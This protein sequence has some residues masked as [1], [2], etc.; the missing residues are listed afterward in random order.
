MYDGGSGEVGDSAVNLLQPILPEVILAAFALLL[1]VG[2]VF[3]RREIL[4]ALALLGPAVSATALVGQM[5]GRH[6]LMPQEFF[7]GMFVLDDFGFFFRLAILI[8]TF[9]VALLSVGERLLPR[10]FLG[11]YFSLLLFSALGMMF[12]VSTYDMLMLFLAF[13]FVGIGSYVLTGFLK[14]NVK[15]AEAG[16]KYFLVGTFSSAVMLYGL[17]LIFGLSGSTHLGSAAGGNQPLLKMAILLFLVGAG[18]KISMVPFHMWAP[19]AYEGAP[20]PI[21][22]FISVVPKI[23]GLAVLFRIFW[24]GPWGE[25]MTAFPLAA[26]SIITMTVGNLGALAQSNIKRML[27]YSSIAQVGYML[28][29]FV[30]AAP[31]GLLGVALYLLA[32]MVMN[33]GAFAVVIAV[34]NR[35]GGEDLK[36]FAGL[37]QRSPALA[38]VMALF[39]LSLAGIPPTAGFLGKF[40]VFGAAIDK[41]YAWL[42]VAG[43]LN[44]VLSLYYYLRVV[45]QMYFEGASPT[46]KPLAPSLSL[47]LAIGLCAVFT[48]ALG[49]YPGPIIEWLS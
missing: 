2:A 26:L 36:D 6:A 38:F 48:M 22:G 37:S 15:S 46:E 7:S 42:A 21:T 10:N 24:L 31:W 32:Y 13:E 14:G 35:G 34:T 12:L 27:A 20:T 9:L 45:Y 23:A 8:S 4:V 25:M 3:F 1:M 29:G 11:E 39:F 40:M 41:G 30:S 17:T 16:V 43:A 28:I 33:L 44:S 18:F 47:K 5:C 19:E 49:L